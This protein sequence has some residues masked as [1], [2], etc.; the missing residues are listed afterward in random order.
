MN[1]VEFTNIVR[2]AEDVESPPIEELNGPRQ[3]A[4]GTPCDARRRYAMIAG[5]V[6]LSAW[7]AFAI[8]NSISDLNAQL[9]MIRADLMLPIYK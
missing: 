2:R 9:E 6:L 5:I 3:P 8:N 7:L 4:P 1:A